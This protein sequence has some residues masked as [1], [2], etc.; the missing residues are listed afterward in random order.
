MLQSLWRL[1]SA[2]Y[3][4]SLFTP[5]QSPKEQFG[6]LL[7][8]DKSTVTYGLVEFIIVRMFFAMVFLEVCVL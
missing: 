4:N 3:N 7:I 2:Q 5:R 8:G 6:I 1:R